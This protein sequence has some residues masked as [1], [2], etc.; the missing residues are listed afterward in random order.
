[1]ERTIPVILGGL[2]ALAGIV[3]I[4]YKVSEQA[5]TTEVPLTQEPLDEVNANSEISGATYSPPT[6][7]Q[8]ITGSNNITDE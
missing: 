5:P 6:T 7:S 3:Y 8:G 1:M 4:V 2:V